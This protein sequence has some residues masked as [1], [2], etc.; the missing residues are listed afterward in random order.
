M[1][2]SGRFA[3]SR[4]DCSSLSAAALLSVAAGA[5]ARKAAAVEKKAAGRRDVHCQD[6][7]TA[8]QS[9]CTAYGKSTAKR[10]K[11]SWKEELRYQVRHRETTNQP[12]K[13]ITRMQEGGSDEMKEERGRGLQPP[14]I[15]GHLKK[16]TER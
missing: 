13:E 3:L 2:R 9:A 4:Q 12:G 6:E 1:T 8:R 7:C 14:D 5:G 15:L 10:I 11:K 16:L